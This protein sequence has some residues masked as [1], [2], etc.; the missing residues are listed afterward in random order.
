M[1]KFLEGLMKSF[2]SI[3]FIFSF[4]FALLLCLS[5]TSYN[6]DTSD[7]DKSPQD[8]Y[9]DPVSSDSILLVD[10][11]S[12]KLV[13]YNTKKYTVEKRMNALN[14]MIY[15]F[16]PL[17]RYMTS[18][19]SIN[20]G[21]EIISIDSVVHTVY[22]MKPNEGIF[23]LAYY[24]DDYYFI[25]SQYDKYGV[26]T[27]RVLVKF[28]YIKNKLIEYTH[29]HGLVSYGT[30]IDDK[31]YYTV[32]NENNDDYTLYS[33][34]RDDFDSIPKLEKES[35]ENGEI[36]SQGGVLYVT[37]RKSIISDNKQFKKE[38]QN[39]FIGENYLVQYQIQKDDTL[40][41]V[42]IDTSTGE[43]IFTAENIV[44]FN[45]SNEEII[46]YCEGCIKKYPLKEG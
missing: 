40:D 3:S 13:S 30:V 36:F 14:H 32:Y 24:S 7:N 17:A 25:K 20:F 18:G 19:H 39:Y 26:E 31:L 43:K 1:T 15:E 35:L 45:V 27:D 5:L 11:F 44:D 33:L 22:S 4:I 9:I 16:S 34:L 38:T 46:F 21:F 37:N 2:K 8:V 6:I 10:R 41:A 28:D 42:V 23:P 12:Q 29:A